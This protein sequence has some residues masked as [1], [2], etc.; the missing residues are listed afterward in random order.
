MNEWM[1]EN[2]LSLFNGRSDSNFIIDDSE[3]AMIH[4]WAPSAQIFGIYSY[5]VENLKDEIEFLRMRC[6]FN[7]KLFILLKQ[8][9]N[10]EKNMKN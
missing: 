8:T 4:R 6:F 1:K 7:E 5:N 9:T 10:V 3:K 2:K